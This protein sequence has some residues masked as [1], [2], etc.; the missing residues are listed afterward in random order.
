MLICAQAI[1]IK[2]IKFCYRCWQEGHQDVACSCINGQKQ[3][4]LRNI[5]Q[6]RL[7]AFTKTCM[8]NTYVDEWPSES[9]KRGIFCIITIDKKNINMFCGYLQRPRSKKDLEEN[10]QCYRLHNEWD[11]Q[12]LCKDA[13]GT[14]NENYLKETITFI[15]S[16]DK[17]MTREKRK[18]TI[19][20]TR[21]T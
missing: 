16:G 20:L 13:R 11:E 7:V 10:L 18:T 5:L 9:D 4:T 6:W 17:G 12:G 2:G 1:A 19:T 15:A 21:Q 14:N 3:R 8:N